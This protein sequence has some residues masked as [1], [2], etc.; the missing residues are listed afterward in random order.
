MTLNQFIRD[1]RL[2]PADAIVMRKK[3]FGM[4]DH[5]VIYLGLIRNRHTFVANYTQGVKIIPNNE[6]IQFLSFLVPKS[7]EAFPGNEYQRKFAVHRAK[8]R[9]G[10]KA[11]DY[12]AN[13]CEHYKN[14]VH[15]GEHKSIQADGAKTL[16][17]T[18]AIVGIIAA[19]AN[20]K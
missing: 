4:V 16:F 13:N 2:R 18:L 3:L 7:I 10:E 14:F 11:Y 1:N 19:I 6:L 5:Y 8:S 20:S 12:L 17:G 15:Y 9:I